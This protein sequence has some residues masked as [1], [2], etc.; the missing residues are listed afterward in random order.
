M[1][2]WRSW[3]SR[4]PQKLTSRKFNL[5]QVVLAA[6]VSYLAFRIISFLFLNS[7]DTAPE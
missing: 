6:I 4:L 3:L 7:L 1:R 5:Y 2:W